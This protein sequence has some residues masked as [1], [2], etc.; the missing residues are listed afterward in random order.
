MITKLMGVRIKE[1]RAQTGLSQE[2]FAN[3]IDMARTYF[4]E[5]ETGK[6]N[7][8]LRNLLKIV[9]GLGVTLEE[10]FDSELFEQ[11]YDEGGPELDARRPRDPS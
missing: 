5:V 2:S 11:V 7:I 3:K 1:L 4:A 9:N 8:S 10:F 6:R